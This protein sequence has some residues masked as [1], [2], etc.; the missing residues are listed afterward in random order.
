MSKHQLKQLQEA[1]AEAY[2]LAKAQSKPE[3][4]VKQ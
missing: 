2:A 1:I 3:E 4:K